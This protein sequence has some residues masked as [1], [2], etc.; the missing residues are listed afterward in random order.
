MNWN[1]TSSDIQDTILRNWLPRN[2]NSN[3]SNRIIQPWNLSEGTIMKKQQESVARVK[4]LIWSS[5]ISCCF[6]KCCFPK[7]A[8]SA[9][10]YVGARHVFSTNEQQKDCWQPKKLR[11]MILHDHK[12]IW[13]K[14]C[15]CNS[16]TSL[17]RSMPHPWFPRFHFDSQKD[18]CFKRN[19]HFAAQFRPENTDEAL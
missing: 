16:C 9:R 18:G 15:C 5:L 17:Q 6:P 14:I 10:H 8:D 13:A 3:K 19:D 7:W 4:H 1:A 11:C 2:W 12:I